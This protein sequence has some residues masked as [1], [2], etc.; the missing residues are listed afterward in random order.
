MLP[1]F[2]ALLLAQLA[3]RSAPLLR[4]RL[5]GALPDSGLRFTG[6]VAAPPEGTGAQWVQGSA[7]LVPEGPGRALLLLHLTKGDP[8]REHA[9]QLFEGRCGD[10]A[11]IVPV[12]APAIAV[13]A[14][15]GRANAAELLDLD[16]AATSTYHV[17]VRASAN[18]TGSLAGCADLT[19]RR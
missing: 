16:L 12:M 11:M 8:G 6:E 13:I 9:F 2:N 10:D 4:A 5:A 1:L 7:E 18:G 19:M 3:L 15:N 17:N 14:E